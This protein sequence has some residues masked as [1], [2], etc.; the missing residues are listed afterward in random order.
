MYDIFNTP[1]SVDG[2]EENHVNNGNQLSQ[3]NLKP[4]R[5]VAQRARSGKP[6]QD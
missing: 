6:L 1:G 4:L 3:L 2:Q 5:T